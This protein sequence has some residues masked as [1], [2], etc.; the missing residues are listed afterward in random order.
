MVIELEQYWDIILDRKGLKME[1]KDECSIYSGFASVYD[2][3]MDNIPYD[4]WAEYV[5]TLLAESGIRQGI[6]VELACGTGELTKRLADSGYQM[7]GVDFSE[8]MLTIARDKCGEEVLLLHQDMRELELYGTAA[9][10][11]CVCD[12]MNYICSEEELG[13]V[14][15]RAYAFLDFSGVLIFDMKTDYFFREVLGNQTITDNREDASYIWENNYYEEEMLN[16]YLLTV[17]ELV[18][19][20]RDLFVRTDELHYQRAYD[21]AVVKHCLEEQGFTCVRI[22]EAMTKQQ[23]Q[24]DSERIYFVAYKNAGK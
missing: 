20:E 7:I 22:F 14:F 13:Q 19:E 3:F 1:N 12:G 15:Q 4:D 5:K 6:V 17:Y 16:E 8:E 9:A 11:V 24:Q 23:P 2:I 21:I 18:D 10:M